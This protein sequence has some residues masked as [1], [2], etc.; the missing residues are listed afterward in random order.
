MAVCTSWA[1]LSALRDKA[2]WSAICVLL[3]PLLEVICVN[4]AISPN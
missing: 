2:N 4:P 3:T 1:T